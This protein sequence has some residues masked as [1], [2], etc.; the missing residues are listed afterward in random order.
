MKNKNQ[1]A[2]ISSAQNSDIK[3]NFEHG[4]TKFRC[5]DNDLFPT[6]DFPN[7]QHVCQ[8]TLNCHNVSARRCPHEHCKTAVCR[9]HFKNKLQNFTIIPVTGKTKQTET[10]QLNFHSD[11]LHDGRDVLNEAAVSS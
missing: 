8:L 11:D 10:T 1:W 5:G 6:I 3:T 4:Q 7:S 9:K 2:E